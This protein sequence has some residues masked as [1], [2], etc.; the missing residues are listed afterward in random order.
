MIILKFF[1]MLILIAVIFIL[2]I[3]L[4]AAFS[5][6]NIFRQVTGK[7]NKQPF[8]QQNNSQNQW[9]NNSGQ[10]N[11]S[12]N[13]WYNNS[14]QQNAQQNTSSTQ[15]T[16]SGK[17]KPRNSVIDKNEGEYVDFEEIP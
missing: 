7:G 14:S 15:S 4:S 2:M 1:G 13:Q 11:N 3:A 16:V 9:Y 5:F 8:G 10:Q 6:W 17:P 12:Q